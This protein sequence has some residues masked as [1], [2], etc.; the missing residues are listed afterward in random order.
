MNCAQV[1]FL[2]KPFCSQHTLD[3][4]PS[5]LGIGVLSS[6]WS[7]APQSSPASPNVNGFVVQG[8]ILIYIYK[9]I[10]MMV[11]MFFSPRSGVHALSAYALR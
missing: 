8:P 9:T 10:M 5:P 11:I 3:A 6:G 1:R 4:H 2:G 7:V